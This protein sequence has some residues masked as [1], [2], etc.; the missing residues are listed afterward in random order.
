MMHLTNIKRKDNIISA[1]FKVL[2]GNG[3]QFHLDVDINTG[4]IVGNTRRAY[5]SYELKGRWKLIKICNE[6]GKR[7]PK[8]D[9]YAWY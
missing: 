1:D 3:E 2:D 5:D 8:E 6:Y 4:E 9:V 7:V